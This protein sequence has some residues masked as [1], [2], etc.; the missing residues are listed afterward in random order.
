MTNRTRTGLLLLVLGAG[1]AGCDGARAPGPTAP[2]TTQS[3][4][5]PS[6]VAACSMPGVTLSGV[7]SEVTLTGSVPIEGARVFLSDD[8]DILTDSLGFF[9]F[10]S[11]CPVGNTIIWV[12]KDGYDDSAAHAG[13]R[14]LT[15]NGD[16]RLAITLV[17]R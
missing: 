4:P 10:T 6:P 7:V 9:S 1:L 16:T 2:S 5:T 8:Q 13:W 17:R 3:T 15:I 14:V 11:V 12:G